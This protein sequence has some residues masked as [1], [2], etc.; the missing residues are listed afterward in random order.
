MKLVKEA[1]EDVLKPRSFDE[2]DNIMQ[3]RLIS[4]SKDLKI[5]NKYVVQDA[6]TLEWHDGFEYLGHDNMSKE[7]IF[8]YR[9]FGTEIIMFPIP[10]GDLKSS[11]AHP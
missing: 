9:E 2:V 6:G 8:F 5:G 7:H 11:V 1:L 4:G 10:D 3:G